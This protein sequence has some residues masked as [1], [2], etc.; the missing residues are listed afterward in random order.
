MIT[1]SEADDGAAITLPVGAAFSVVLRE[2]PTTGFRWRTVSVDAAVLN[3]TRDEFH[4]AGSQRLGAGGEH[5]WEFTTREPGSCVIKLANGRGWE[6]APA[7]RTFE[8]KV[9][10]IE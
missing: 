3:V 6:S 4:S 7:I 10:V 2:S 1:Y 8:L 9:N 5:L